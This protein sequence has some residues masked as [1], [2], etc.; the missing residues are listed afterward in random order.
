[1]IECR[2][3]GST[4]SQ[5]QLHC[6]YS[7]GL[8]IWQKRHMPALLG[9]RA[10]SLLFFPNFLF[11]VSAR[12]PKSGAP[13]VPPPVFSVSARGPKEPKVPRKMS[14]TSKFKNLDPKERGP[15]RGFFLC[16]ALSFKRGSKSRA[17]NKFFCYFFGQQ[18]P[19]SEAKKS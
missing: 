6:N 17:T 7:A 2:H 14:K 9:A 3:S 8:T 16:L 19:K 10:H 5:T 15:K 13:N 11:P 4:Q 12:A 18:A 1:M